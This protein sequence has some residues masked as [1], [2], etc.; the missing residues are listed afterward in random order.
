MVVTHVLNFPC[1]GGGNHVCSC[2]FTLKFD[3]LKIHVV[4]ISYMC[5]TDEH[6]N[7]NTSMKQHSSHPS[8]FFRETFLLTWITSPPLTAQPT[9]TISATHYEQMSNFSVGSQDCFLIID[10]LAIPHSQFTFGWYLI[11]NFWESLIITV[12]VS[13]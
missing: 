4:N 2:V 11:R 3:P 10:S 6:S 13:L 8:T 9:S 5:K 7:L 1:G 12:N